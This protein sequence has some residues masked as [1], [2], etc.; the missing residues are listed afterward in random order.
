MK[1]KLKKKVSIQLNNWE[2]IDENRF[3]QLLDVFNIKNPFEGIRTLDQQI[4]VLKKAG[5]ISPTEILLGYRVAMA[6]NKAT[7]SYTPK[8]AIETF[9]YVSIIDVLK[10]V[11]LKSDVRT[12]IFNEQAAPNGT[13]SSFRDGD[14]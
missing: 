8:M 2:L 1:N 11:L 7:C 6:L 13:S 9:Q 10:M 5:Y 14:Y 12:A 4:E 3:K